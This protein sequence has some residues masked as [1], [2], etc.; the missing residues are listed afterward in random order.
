MILAGPQSSGKTTLLV[1]LIENV[2][3]MFSPAPAHILYCY[4]EYNEAI[5]RLQELNVEVH[6]GL[7]SDEILNN[8]KKPL[9]LLMDDLMLHVDKKYLDLLVTVK[10][11]HRNIG[12]IFVAQNLF[13]KNLKTA[14]DNSQYIIVMKS[15]SSLRTI[16]DIGTSLFPG[17]TKE[18]MEIYEEATRK[19]YGYL[20]MNLHAG[21][22]SELRLTQTFSRT[23]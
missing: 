21:V 7:P 1:K 18:F 5:P 22:D 9:L 14:R 23:S 10:S 13:D 12:V 19:K 17:K 6:S 8:S 16:R 2:E 20:L 11:H 4:S 3:K 15:P